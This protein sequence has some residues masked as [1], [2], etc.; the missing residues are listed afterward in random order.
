MVGIGEG[1][2]WQERFS[3]EIRFSHQGETLDWLAGLYYEDSNDSWNSVW[4]KDAL[5]PYPQSLSYAFIEA[6][7][8]GTVANYLCYGSSSANGLDKA[9]PAAVA[10]ALLT[11]DHYWDSRDD[12]DWKTKAVFGEVVWHIADQ[13]D[14]TVGGRWFETTNDKVYIK[15][16]AGHTGS[17]D[18]KTGGFIQPIWMGNEVTQ[19]EKI[20]EF[21]P[22]LSL[23]YQIDDAK[24]V[25]ALYSEGYRTGGINRANRQADW[26]RTL[27][28]QAW[29]PDKLKNYELGLKSR[30]AN[31]TVQFNLTY[32]YMDWQDFQHEVVDPSVGEC[33]VPEEEPQC[34]P[35][36]AL[37]WI[38]IV[39]NV[40]DAHSTGFQAELD[41]VPADRWVLGG[42]AMWLEAEIDSTTSG[43]EAGIETGQQLPNTPEFQGAL[44]ATYTWPVEFISGGEMFLRGQYSYTGK[45]HTLLVPAGLDS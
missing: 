26:S 19:S 20:S 43:P 3:Q 39:G 42:N 8:N 25:Y 45:T 33:I 4:M 37:P 12:T 21:V 16:L 6:C 2:E 18:R 5:T 1:P 15:Y 28:P 9:D 10:A 32:F 44:W 29:N 13:W 30:W 27:W 36:G 38:S 11:A 14:L 24:M 35:S 31:D 34:E 22:K 17:D 23:A 41:W 7:H 40:G